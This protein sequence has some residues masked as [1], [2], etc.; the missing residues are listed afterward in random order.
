TPLQGRAAAQLQLGDR[1]WFRHAKSGEPAE[2]ID[3]Y[4]LVAGSE[5]VE[6]LPTYRGEGKAF[7]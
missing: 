2:R 1:V 6:E 4:H 5:I 3:R 7:L